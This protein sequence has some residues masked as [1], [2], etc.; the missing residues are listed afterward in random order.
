MYNVFINRRGVSERLMVR[1]WKGRVGATPPW[2]RIPSPLNKTEPSFASA[3]FYYK[4]THGLRKSNRKFEK[5]L[6]KL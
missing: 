5:K 2:V 1:S 6:R 3:R 4:I